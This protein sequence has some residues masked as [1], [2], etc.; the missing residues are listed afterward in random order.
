MCSLADS[1]PQ[2]FW[3]L[4]LATIL[5]AGVESYQVVAVVLLPLKEVQL[6][7]K[8]FQPHSAAVMLLE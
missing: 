7:L 4:R 6:A 1:H 2:V 8:A 5:V 3:E